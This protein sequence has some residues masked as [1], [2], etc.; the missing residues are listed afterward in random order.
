MNSK[1]HLYVC[2]AEEANEVA[3]AALAV[4]KTIHKTLRF[5]ESNG[6]PGRNMT[7]VQALVSELND[8]EACVEL[9]IEAGVPL[10]GLHDRAHIDEKKQR[11]MRYMH[12]GRLNGVVDI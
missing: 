4:S 1:E 10:D 2:G 5:S 3:T 9:L 7:N 8:L 12:L 6:W 11:V